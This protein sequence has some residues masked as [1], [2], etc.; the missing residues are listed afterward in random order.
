MAN[1]K[2]RQ[3]A[4]LQELIAAARAM[5]IHV[6]SEK[7]LREAGYRVHSGRC[8]IKGQN[9]ILLDRDSPIADQIEL[10]SHE[11][12]ERANHTTV[13]GGATELPGHQ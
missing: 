1:T 12:A 6:R 13:S 2:N 8:R 5:N 7:L 11:L 9:V 3:E 10:L 4:R